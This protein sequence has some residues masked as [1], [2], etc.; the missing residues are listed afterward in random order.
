MDSPL[1]PGAERFAVSPAERRMRSLRSLGSRNGSQPGPG[2]IYGVSE[3]L[4]ELVDHWR[5]DVELTRRIGLHLVADSLVGRAL[6]LDLLLEHAN[7]VDETLGAR[8][9]TRNVHVNRN[10]RVDSLHHRVIVEHSAS[11]GA[12]AHRDTPF[13]LRHLLPD[14]A[15][16][17]GELEGD[18]TCADKY[19]G[20]PRRVAHAFH[21]EAREFEIAGRSRHELDRA[22]RRPNRHWPQGV[23]ASPIDQEVEA[24]RDPAFLRF[25]RVRNGPTLSG[26][27]QSHCSAPFFHT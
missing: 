27:G 15:D 20:L 25:W 3:R 14:A 16:N 17:R 24:S 1:R 18:A 22:A 8:R 21:P 5:R 10:D 19:V 11:R 13:G 4:T 23:G 9:A 26:S 6:V 12:G 2:L 7:A